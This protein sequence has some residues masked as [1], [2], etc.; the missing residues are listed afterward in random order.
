MAIRVSL[1]CVAIASKTAIGYWKEEF[2]YPVHARF[3]MLQ[4]HISNAN[5][6]TYQHL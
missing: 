1:S 6:N 4:K 5:P 3:Q 2:D